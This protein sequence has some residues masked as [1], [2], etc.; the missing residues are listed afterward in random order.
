[1]HC[2]PDVTLNTDSPFWVSREV[3]FKY[4]DQVDFFRR[5]FT[6]VVPSYLAAWFHTRED[7]NI[8]F[9]LPTVMFVDDK[10]QFI[11][12]RHRTAVLL[13]HLK[14]IPIAFSLFNRPP[15]D[16]LNQ[17]ALRSLA[18]HEYI[19]LPDLPIMENLP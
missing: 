3:F 5:E 12:G 17:L 7:G 1:M 2:L 19:E 14:D 10:T 13:P 18:L 15:Q 6:N 4:F 9:I 11:S 8:R 16:F